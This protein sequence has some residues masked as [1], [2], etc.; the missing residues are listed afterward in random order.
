MA[1]HLLERSRAQISAEAQW[2]RSRL[3][4]KEML[5]HV[6]ALH[7]VLVL[8]GAFAVGLIPTLLLLHRRHI[9]ASTTARSMPAPSV[10]QSPLGRLIAAQAV[11][12]LIPLVVMPCLQSSLKHHFKHEPPPSSVP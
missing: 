8:G 5:R 10:R 7:P 9:A 1:L 4:P 2:L 3:V 6:V 11:R 12:M